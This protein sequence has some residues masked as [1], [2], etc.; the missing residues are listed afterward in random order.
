MKLIDKGNTRRYR[1]SRYSGIHAASV[2]LSRLSY[3]PRK[4]L[5]V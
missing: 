4:P 3:G 2:A 5:R 1:P